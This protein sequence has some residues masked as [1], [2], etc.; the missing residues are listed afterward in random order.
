MR[1]GLALYIVLLLVAATWLPLATAQDD[2]EHGFTPELGEELYALG[3]GYVENLVLYS[4]AG[5]SIAWGPSFDG[6]TSALA[7]RLA[8]L[9]ENGTGSMPPMATPVFLPFHKADPT[10][11]GP[12]PLNHSQMWLWNGS[13]SAIVDVGALGY[14]IKAESMLI[15]NTTVGLLYA[16]AATEAVS[17]ATEF[18]GVNETGFAPLNLS[19]ANMTDA[20][21]TNGYWL[22][23]QRV[24]GDL[25]DTYDPPMWENLTIRDDV[26][27]PAIFQFLEGLNALHEA[28]STQNVVGSGKAF[29]Q[30]TLDRLEAIT[31]AV[32]WNMIG[33]YNDQ[34][35]WAGDHAVSVLAMFYLALEDIA[36]YRQGDAVGDHAAGMLGGIASGLL[37][38]MD[39]DGS[40][41]GSYETGSSGITSAGGEGGGATLALVAS[42][43]CDADDRFG[44]FAYG[45]AARACIAYMD[46][47]HWDD[48]L[49]L[50]VDDPDSD[51]VSIAS[52]YEALAMEAYG[53][54]LEVCEVELAK[55]RIPQLW[56]GMVAAGVQLSETDA[57]GENY[58]AMGND[59]DMDGI[60]KHNMSWGQGREH[61]V[62][63][64][65]AYGADMDSDGNWTLHNNGEVDVFSLMVAALVFMDHDWDWFTS[66]GEPAYSEAYASMV[67]HWTDQQLVDYFEA[68]RAEIEAL[69]NATSNVSDEV[70]RLKENITYLIENNTALTLDLNDSLENESILNDTV[71]WLRERFEEANETIDELNTEIEILESKIGRLEEGLVERDEN[72]TDLEEKLRE[73]RH[74]ATQLQWELDNAS[75][76]M[77]QAFK[78][79]DKA[80]SDKEDAEERLSDQ[81]GRSF[82]TAIIAL[83]AG[84]IIILVLLRLMNKI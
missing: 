10:F 28:M 15:D 27:F 48:G 17:Y 80:V 56:M 52:A 39:E 72:V 76:A 41:A 8:E 13:T 44:G 12:A 78:D 62:A 43:L 67:L 66:L 83:V 29:H 14:T 69:Q 38:L 70:K 31:D 34:S 20:N 33:Y 65:L 47:N 1:R 49:G 81:E 58:S 55:Y 32:Y 54:V 18:L 9:E 73:A 4:G 25:N 11:A 71:N 45:A 19:D 40:I 79:R 35:M 64:V 3:M 61:G 82:F 75:A 74:N 2:P 60:P 84:M 21:M 7:D 37:S 24:E 59:T 5:V 23:L 16:L 77:E 30:A 63:P 53:D 42:A 36:S 50:V 68:R 22:P 6:N 51:P 46:A 26:F 57:T